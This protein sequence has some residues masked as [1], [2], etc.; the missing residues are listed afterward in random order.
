MVV[1]GCWLGVDASE[2]EPAR[3]VVR[4]GRVVAEALLGPTSRQHNVQSWEWCSIKAIG[5][6]RVYS[7]YMNL[8]A[9]LR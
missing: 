1:E 3:E 5:S 7:T 2:V 8:C 6:V 9:Q 4:Y